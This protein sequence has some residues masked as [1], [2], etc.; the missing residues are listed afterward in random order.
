MGKYRMD[1]LA[2]V[3]PTPNTKVRNYFFMSDG[4]YEQDSF[5]GLSRLSAP[6]V[7]TQVDKTAD[8]TILTSDMGKMFTNV[9]A[10]G[11]VVLTL[12]PALSVLGRTITIV[13]SADQNLT[14]KSVRSDVI[15]YGGTPA[16]TIANTL[17]GDVNT[18]VTL[19]AIKLNS[20][21]G[22]WCIQNAFGQW[23]TA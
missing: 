10:V 8:Y 11:A 23:V 13:K 21:I 16:G 12:P 14:A 1:E 2:S 4:F 3:P 19:F 6:F 20:G 5:G 7:R 22:A 15:S 18:Q 17:A 9:G